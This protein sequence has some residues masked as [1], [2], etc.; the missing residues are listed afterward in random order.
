MPF[1]TSVALM[2]YTFEVCVCACF[3]PLILHIGLTYLWFF[4]SVVQT[5]LFESLLQQFYAPP[6]S[7]LIHC[8]AKEH[9]NQS[10]FEQNLWQQGWYLENAINQTQLQTFPWQKK[11][12]ELPMFQCMES[13]QFFLRKETWENVSCFIWE[14]RFYKFHFMC[15]CVRVCLYMPAHA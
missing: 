7:D 2:K 4:H 10:F 14:N 12:F 6:V 15:V 11:V 13:K 8:G 9:P 3:F 5:P 1:Q